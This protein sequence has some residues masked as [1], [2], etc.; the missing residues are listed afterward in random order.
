MSL[1]DLDLPTYIR[2]I[3]SREDI[4]TLGELLSWTP[5]RLLGIS[6]FGHKSL[7]EVRARLA[8]RGL[9]LLGAA[10]QDDGGL[11]VPGGQG[12]EDAGGSR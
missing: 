8:E 10:S 3:L 12:D 2:S 4:E 1:D 6:G 5:D 7:E 11:E 9:D